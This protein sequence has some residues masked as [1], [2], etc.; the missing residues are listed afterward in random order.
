[1]PPLKAAVI[2]VGYLGRFHAAKYAALPDV[3][4]VGV[5]DTRAAQAEAVARDLG[6]RAFGDHR[7]LIGRVDAVSIVVPTPAHFTVSRDFL[8][9]GVDVLIEKPITTRLDEAD[10][11]IRLAE[12][13]GR[14]IQVGHLERFNPALQAA[15]PHIGRVRF[16]DSH[17]LSPYQPRGTDVSVVLDLMIHDIDL[18]LSVAAGPLEEIR[19]AGMALVSA[20]TDIASA[21]LTF[22]SG[23]V[24]NL[25]A[26]RLAARSDRKM[27]L[28][29]SDG[30]LT[31]DFGRHQTT[32]LR[33]APR[34]PAPADTEGM[35]GLRIE[36]LDPGPGDALAAEIRAFVTAVRRRAEPVVSGR[37]GRAAL[38]VALEIMDAIQRGTETFNTHSFPEP[39]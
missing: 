38:A 18:I 29:Q 30:C 39:S 1:M 5:A 24:A 36:K 6:C 3:V 28:F 14:L 20:H 9:N 19:A 23:C 25:T 13:R 16:I 12:A 17:R 32:L 27:R 4:L 31:V 35:A 37:Q 22:A 11:L 7:E 33:P 10:A 2:G 26:S 34:D 15:R 8:E 21:R